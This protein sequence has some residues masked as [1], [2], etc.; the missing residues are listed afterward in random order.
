M[1][2]KLEQ[3]GNPWALLPL[4]IFIVIFIFS[5]TISG[6]F[7]KM[8]VIVAFL[9]SAFVALIMNKKRTF[10]N[11]LQDF[12]EGAGNSSIIL[13]CMIF[14]LAGSFAQVCRDMGSIQA[15][16][17][18]GL[19]LLPENILV[20]GLFI[21]TCFIS[22]S[23]GTSVG[24]IAAI[25]PIAITLSQTTGI[26]P[27]LTLGAVIGGAMFG[28]NLSFISDTTIASTRTQNCK[29]RDKFKVN[30]L[31][32]LPAAIITIL[33]YAF[34]PISSNG[35]M[36]VNLD[37]NLWKIIP[38]IVVLITALIG[39]NVFIV[40]G[41]GLCIASI[42]GLIQ[43]NFDFW[44]LVD[45]IS[46]GI[47][48]MSELVI[49]CLLIGGT[50]NLIRKNGGIQFVL[51]NIQKR[52]KNKRGA[53]IGIATLV[54]LVNL[55]TANNTIAIII[56]GPI[57]KNI[58]TDYHIK[59]SRS[60]GI[61][62]TFSCVIQSI[63]PYGAQVLAAVSVASSFEINI[64]PTKII[65]YLYYPFLMAISAILFILL[66]KNKTHQT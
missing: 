36:P 11:K 14:I 40:L 55:C 66:K 20:S 51:Y 57:A 46:K 17:N 34:D 15:T 58:A 10:D 59:G 28:D 53:E 16:T 8:P 5:S 39:I 44:Q 19:S 13:M 24:T 50:V 45:S 33:L 43:G 4:L 2:S 1:N 32:V 35:H 65:S 26:N 29:M 42:I 64:D 38:Y 12:C 27:S 61:L 52:I 49:I 54:A 63:I 21:I 56:A 30:F 9:I 25:S 18:L 3:K 22:L 37:Y 60:A 7:Y 48:S 6:S 23:I 41:S 31:I 47:G 62:D